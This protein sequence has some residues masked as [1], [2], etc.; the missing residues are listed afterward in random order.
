MTKYSG[1]GKDW[2]GKELS[3]LTSGL[4]RDSGFENDTVPNE[5]PNPTRALAMLVAIP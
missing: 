1:L 5:I 3:K 2:G 4:K